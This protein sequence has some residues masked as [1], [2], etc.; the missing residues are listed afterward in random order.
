MAVATIEEYLTNVRPPV[1]PIAQMLRTLIESEF[2]DTP[3]R[4]YQGIPVWSFNGKPSIGIKANTN[5]VALLLFA[6]QRIVDPTGSL[7][8]SGSFEMA[9]VKLRTTEDVD[10]TV[11]RGWVRQARAVET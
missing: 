4:M 9:S 8:P 6:G 11:I 2:P 5:D 1:R 10:E 7:T 3:S